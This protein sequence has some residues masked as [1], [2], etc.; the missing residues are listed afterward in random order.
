MKTRAGRSHQQ[1]NEDEKAIT[2]CRAH[3]LTVICPNLLAP[4]VTVIALLL[5]ARYAFVGLAAWASHLTGHICT[6]EQSDSYDFTGNELVGLF[7]R[8]TLEGNNPSC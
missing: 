3:A 4:L 5:F 6:L 7:R 8:S 1:T 2:E